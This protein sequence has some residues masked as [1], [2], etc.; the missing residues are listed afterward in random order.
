MTDKERIARIRKALADAKLDAL[1]CSLPKNVLLLAGYW[2]V[3]GTSVAIAF[4]DGNIQLIVPADEQELGEQGWADHV[5]T[6]KPAPLD[7]LTSASEQL[8]EPLRSLGKKLEGATVCVEHGEDTE[9]STYA[10]MH[11]YQDSLRDALAKAFPKAKLKCA[12]GTLRRLRS[13]KTEGE[14]E[15]I[16]NACAL[17]REAFEQGTKNL[18]PGTTEL[19]A[20]EAFRSAFKSAQA[21]VS[22]IHRAEAF[23]WAMSGKNAALAH[24]AYARS[25]PK[26]IEPGDLVLVHCNTCADGYWTDITRT[27]SLGHPD[28]KRN[29]MYAAVFAAREAALQAVVPGRRGSEIDR[30]ARRV[31]QDLGFGKEFKHS[32]GHGIGFGAISPDAL[33]RL[34]P[35]SDDVIEPG[36]VFNVEPAIYIEGYGGIRH[37]NMVCVTKNGYELLSDFLT[38]PKELFLPAGAKAAT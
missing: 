23:F 8:L 21:Q 25:R 37:C 9:P 30:A 28:D 16:R 31:L 20:A 5:Q 13:V 14:I 38:N 24:G 17:T 1:V 22:G 10:A 36:S 15:R 34:H 4:A 33:P 12:D 27:F 32:T 7:Q 11:L 18:R 3:V 29:K 2:P 6:F 26:K 19:E 35:K